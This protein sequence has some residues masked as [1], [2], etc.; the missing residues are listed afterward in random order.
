MEERE[1]FKTIWL[2]G[3]CD[4]TSNSLDESALNSGAP[5]LVPIANA[6]E[7]KGI[8]GHYTS[9]IKC[10]PNKIAEITDQLNG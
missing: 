1:R 8:C 6:K 4:V 5:T 7:L 3:G 2:A 9:L 10:K